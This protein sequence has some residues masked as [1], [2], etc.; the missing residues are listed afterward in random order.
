MIVLDEEWNK[1]PWVHIDVTIWINGEE[2]NI[3]LT[4][5]FQLVNLLIEA[6]RELENHHLAI[7]RA[8]IFLGKSH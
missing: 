1:N 7:T 2:G 8:I 6:M 4:V 5:E 3:L